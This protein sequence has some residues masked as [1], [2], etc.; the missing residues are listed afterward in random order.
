MESTNPEAGALGNSAPTLTF[1]CELEPEPL[2]A[3]FADPALIGDLSALHA[4]VSLGILDLSP[5]RAAVVRRLNEAGVHVVAWQLL[6]KPEGYWFNLD[7]AP[8]AVARY[9]A[10]KA[11]TAQYGLSWSG[12]GVD[13]EPD[14]NDIQ[15]LMGPGRKQL[16]L[17]LLRKLFDN[18]RVRRGQIAYQT[19][20]MQ[21]RSDGYRV[22]TYQIP[23][24]VD[25]RAAGAT[26]LQRL[27]GIVDLPAC[28][29]VLMLYTSF[30][31]PSGAALLWSYGRAAQV[32]GVGSTGGGVE[33]GSQVPPL[34]W[35]ELSRDLRVAAR[36]TREIFVFSLEGCVRQG[37]LAQ[38]RDFDW[39]QPVTPPEGLDRVNAIRRALQRVLWG[40]AH[41][42]LVLAGVAA[43]S[44]LLKSC[45]RSCRRSS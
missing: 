16:M 30:L 32:I 12:I 23:F 22:E 28:R 44:C 6:P 1:A 20:V 43:A 18:E 21:M 7:N 34:T 5:Q 42:W 31:R 11:W 25:E 9:L 26:V 17:P 45:C 27:F 39:E 14:F 2:E 36:W 35:E 29:E 19:L 38:L 41:P 8:K 40:T 10:F 15:R 4:G 3:L 33:I 37:F 24:I 13:I